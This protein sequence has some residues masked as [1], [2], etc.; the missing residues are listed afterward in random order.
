MS[1]NYV[2]KMYDEI[3]IGDEAEI[4]KVVTEEDIQKFS[5]VSLDTNPLHLDEE[6]A[7]KTIFKKRI[8][9]GI[10]GA[11]LISAV[12]GTKLPG[13]NT[14]YMSQTLNFLAPVYIGDEITARVKVVKKRDDKHMIFFETVVVNQDGKK[15]ITGEALVKKD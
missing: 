12:L 7:G 13:V 14:I 4:S 3:K 10:I 6:F 15:V 8:A 1:G 9:H 5:E 11:S 2:E